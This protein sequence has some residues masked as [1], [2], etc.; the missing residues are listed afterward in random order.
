MHAASVTKLFSLVFGR[1]HDGK[2]LSELSE[3]EQCRAKLEEWVEKVQNLESCDQTSS[4]WHP[5]TEVCVLFGLLTYIHLK[6]KRM[7]AIFQKNY[8]GCFFSYR[9]PYYLVKGSSS[10][11]E[12][13]GRKKFHVPWLFRFTVQPRILWWVLAVSGLAQ[14]GSC[15]DEVLRSSVA[16]HSGSNEVQPQLCF[17]LCHGCKQTRCTNYQLLHWFFLF[18]SENYIW[19]RWNL[20]SE[21]GV[22]LQC[23]VPF[24]FWI[25]VSA[26]SRWDECLNLKPNAADLCQN[27]SDSK[28]PDTKQP[29]MVVFLMKTSCSS[30]QTMQ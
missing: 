24:S 5:Q 14:R 30:K 15:V 28:G 11:Q 8:S 6:S 26:S 2:R 17:S 19:T 18:V 16:Q 20:S 3:Q 12:S 29:C 25:E 22:C 27:S 4:G 23:S 9:K 21:R 13:C 10:R 7:R 1:N